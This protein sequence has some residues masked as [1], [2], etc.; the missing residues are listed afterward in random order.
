MHAQENET[1]RILQLEHPFER[2][3]GEFISELKF[4]RLTA[5]DLRAASHCKNDTEMTLKLIARSC[6][7]ADVEFD[8][9]DLEDMQKAGE[10]ISDFL[11]KSQEIGT[12]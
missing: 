9:L 8:K 7:L 12:N 4:R 6:R 2:T 11:P 3:K 10:L 1:Y 5:G